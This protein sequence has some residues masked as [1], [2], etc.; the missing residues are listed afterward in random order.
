MSKKTRDD[1]WVDVHND[2]VMRDMGF[3][4]PFNQAPRDESVW[5]KTLEELR[6]LKQVKHSIKEDGHFNATPKKFVK[7]SGKLVIWLK[8][9]KVFPKTTYSTTCWINNIGDILSNYVVNNKKLGIAESVV[10]KYSFNGK[11]YKPGELPVW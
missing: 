6:K 3:F 2:K 11:T 4:R 5:S 1:L 9:N 8:K 10:T 7:V